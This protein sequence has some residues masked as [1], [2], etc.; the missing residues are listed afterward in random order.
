MR[1]EIPVAGTQVPEEVLPN[2]LQ[3]AACEVARHL[4]IRRSH[5]LQRY[6][7]CVNG[8]LGMVRQLRILLNAGQDCGTDDCGST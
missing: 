1:V 6:G 4:Y 2:E 8:R 7:R 5:E 3:T